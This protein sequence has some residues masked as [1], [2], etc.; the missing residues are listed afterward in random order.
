MGDRVPRA[1]MY[2]R[3]QD[4]VMSDVT[5]ELRRA[6]E[7]AGYEVDRVSENRDSIR[8]A[9]REDAADAGELRAIA[10]DVCGEA[11]VLGFDVTHE[12]TAGDDAVGT[13]VSF[14]HRS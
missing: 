10:T 1:I 9:I 8:I 14:R 3:T 5:D 2:H 11:A 7:S 12:T 13:V 6:F 4:G